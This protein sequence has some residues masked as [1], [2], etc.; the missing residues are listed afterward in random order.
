M[1]RQKYDKASPALLIPEHPRSRASPEHP[2]SRTTP[3]LIQTSVT[4]IRSLENNNSIQLEHGTDA[5]DMPE[6]LNLLEDDTSALKVDNSSL[7]GTSTSIASK[8]EKMQST[9]LNF[10]KPQS[11]NVGNSVTLENVMEAI[12]SLTLKVDDVAKKHHSLMHFVSDDS[13]T[14]KGILRLKAAENILELTGSSSLL[15]WYYDEGEEIG[16]LRCLPC[17]RLHLLSKPTLANLKPREAQRLLS[18][19]SS[20][21]LATG[22]LMKK[23]TSRLLIKGHNT[24]WYH[25]KSSCIEHLCLIGTGSNV[26]K[27]AMDEYNRHLLVEK[28]SLT[29]AKNVFRSVIV[30]LKLGAAG[31]HVETLTSFL[32]LCSV[33]VGSIGHGRKNFKDIFYCLEDTANGK[34]TKWLS[35]PLP[36]TTIPPHYWATVDIKVR[37]V[38][39]Q[40]KLL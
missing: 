4:E 10:G 37:Q 26:H 3:E 5:K 6:Q 40:T 17:F 22:I 14:S 21:T 2:R 30:D 19:S 7:A 35:S 32:A 15:E 34:I 31:Q 36:S 29:A 39:Q 16:I 12:D 24:T 25:R 8:T 18:S 9:L 1:L 33:N 38:E 13:E 11:D 23:E 27:K 20:G 28:R